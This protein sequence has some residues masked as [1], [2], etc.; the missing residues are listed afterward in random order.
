MFKFYPEL[1]WTLY[2]NL[3]T[4][5]WAVNLP[6]KPKVIIDLGA[7]L[8]YTSIYYTLRYWGAEIYAVEAD[9][10][11]F[12]KMA[13]NTR[14]F[15]HIHPIEAAVGSENGKTTF[16]RSESSLASSLTQ[17]RKANIPVMVRSVRLD[18]LMDEQGI[19]E[20]D[21]VK[22]NVEGG[23]YEIFKDFDLSRAHSLIGEY[24]E[25]IVGM[26][27]AKFVAIFGTMETEQIQK[28]RYMCR[29]IGL[30]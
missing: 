26:P 20:A 3:I 13:R 8:G 2:E 17:T 25:D 12:K 18:T 4:Q 22:F 6:Q 27:L 10:V 1:P 7:H 14:F 5:A 30:V 24:H 29:K 23:E 15:K 21:L 19:R 9:P 28:R 11:T 16:Y